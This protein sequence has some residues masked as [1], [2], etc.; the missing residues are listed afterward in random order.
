MQL[1]DLLTVPIPASYNRSFTGLAIDSRTIRP[2]D[3]FCA[4]AGTQTHGRVYIEA[5]LK[6]GAVAIFQEGDT[7]GVDLLADNI[8]CVTIPHLSQRLGNMAARFYDYPS[9]ALRV[10]GV[11]GTNG[12]TSTTH[13][14]AQ[15]LHA[16]PP[17]GLL[18]TLGYGL[19]GA[20]QPG[21]HTTPDA[22]QLQALL[23]QFRAQQAQYA[24]MEVS[25]HALVQGRVNGIQFDT[26]VFTNLSRDHLDYHQ[27]MS[28]YAAAKKQLFFMSG[29]KTAVINLD[30][31]FG[32]TLCQQLPKTVE[33]ITYSLQDNTAD[34]HAHISHSHPRGCQLAVHTR[35]GHSQLHSPLFGHFNASN[36][37]AAMTV[38]LNLGLPITEVVEKL[39]TIHAVPGRM[40][41]FG[42]PHQASVIVDYAHTPDALEKVLLALRA[43]C[44]G[45][46]WCIFG[47]GGNRDRGKRP[48]MGAI[49]H[50]HADKVII[51]DDNPRRETSI[52]IINDILQGCPQPTAVIPDREQA[53]RYVLQQAQM[54]DIVLVAGKG[55]EDYQEIGDHRYPFS[56]RTLVA[57]LLQPSA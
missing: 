28:A 52:A 31:T 2:G 8:P 55:H 13:F 46:L 50:N 47:C 36:L 25:S 26:T 9:H 11:T 21:H 39:G 1:N 7:D 6:R 23:A 17:C 4:L 29:V 34:V 30:D 56:D 54:G 10:I 53:I 32:Q 35:W 40:E 19:Y 27:T 3:V 22:I 38:L 45:T 51:T 41:H 20:L 16:H 14:I 57:T 42:Q 24:V 18:G 15:I 5:A 37:L 33:V 49:A 12:K 48:L 43:H 44:T